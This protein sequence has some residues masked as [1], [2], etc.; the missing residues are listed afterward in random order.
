MRKDIVFVH[1]LGA[2]PDTTWIAKSPLGLV[3]NWVTDI[4]PSDLP[5][6]LRGG[7][8]IHFYNYDTYWKRNAL[9]IRLVDVA[10]DLQIILTRLV[11]TSINHGSARSIVIVAHSYGGLV[12]KQALA[13]AREQNLD[14]TQA[15]RGIIFL[16]CPHHGVQ[17]T[18]APK[19]LA[20]SW[21]LLGANA[22][23]FDEVE[24]N[25]VSLRQTHTSFLSFLEGSSVRIVNFY[26][27]RATAHLPFYASILVHQKD[28]TFESDSGNVLNV[29]LPTDHSGLNKF[30]SRYTP[31]YYQIRNALVDILQSIYDMD[32]EAA[33]TRYVVPFVTSEAFTDRPALANQLEHAM[34]K[35]QS[36][37]VRRYAAAIIGAGGM[38]K[39]QL[40]LNFAEKHRDDYDT[41]I[42][43]NAS[44]EASVKASFNRCCQALDVP[45]ATPVEAAASLGSTPQIKAMLTWLET[46]TAPDQA[47]L[48]IVDNADD[49]GWGIREAMPRLTSLTR[50]SI[51]VTSRDEHCSDILS[52]MPV[53][54]TVESMS[55]HDAISLLLHACRWSGHRYGKSAEP[56]SP[57]PNN[58]A[59]GLLQ[60][61][62]HEHKLRNSLSDTKHER[63]IMKIA[64][65]ICDRLDNY[66][67]AIDL[68]AANIRNASK[69]TSMFEAMAQYYLDYSR[70]RDDLL[71]SEEFHSL[72]SSRQSVWTI[73]DT[74]FDNISEITEGFKCPPMNLLCMLSIF[75]SSAVQREI[76]EQASAGYKEICERLK[77]GDSN[78]LPSWL[79]C[80][81]GVDCNGKWDDYW[82]RRCMAVLERYHLV[83]GHLVDGDGHT[84]H[85][86]IQWRTSMDCQDPAWMQWYV[87]FMASACYN[88]A[89]APEDT[90]VRPLLLAH[91]PTKYIR[92]ALASF[93]VT[94]IA[95]VYLHIGKVWEMEG[96]YPEARHHYLQI[97]R[98]IN[99]ALVSSSELSI[100]QRFYNLGLYLA[101]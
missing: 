41:V 97:T 77:P 35:S 36:I 28:A 61:A 8:N 95:F 56:E 54:V 4:L 38:G 73:W 47:W 14:L 62:E 80:L 34:N 3:V 33:R 87:I 76:F 59:S 81:L 98:Y 72:S 67:L 20:K 64:G 51:I 23:I 58:A 10:V 66:P 15:I 96:G 88:A 93:N 30:A 60:L 12:V 71:I 94:G 63:D 9:K 21:S 82:Y 69:R 40:A 43:I 16:G 17:S 32:A 13:T 55:D 83:R 42:W 89:S 2:N 91:L 27:L 48:M 74:S 7:T 24:S 70:H 100:E 5:P 37:S 49:F 6:A 39:T 29:S 31:G 78:T 50:G 44:S 68:A 18:W 53:M 45:S 86:M 90:S 101:D 11:Q 99:P 22:E 92:P 84:M 52:S 46:R 1:G 85:S 75:D 57:Q 79:R 25:S 65:D 26:E 19:M